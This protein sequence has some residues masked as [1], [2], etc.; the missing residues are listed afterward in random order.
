MVLPSGNRDNEHVYLLLV[1]RRGYHIFNDLAN[2]S[3]H[4]IGCNS[5][6]Y[7][8]LNLH[9]CSNHVLRVEKGAEEFQVIAEKTSGSNWENAMMLAH[10]LY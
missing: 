6:Y 1:G 5:T 8:I 10:R 3:V 9:S 7:S 4:I 2:F